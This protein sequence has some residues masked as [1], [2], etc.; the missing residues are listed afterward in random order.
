[1][2]RDLVAVVGGKVYFSV[3]DTWWVSVDKQCPTAGN[4]RKPGIVNSEKPGQWP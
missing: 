4:Q 1:M 2:R 3:A